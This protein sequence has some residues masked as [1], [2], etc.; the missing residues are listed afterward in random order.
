MSSETWFIKDRLP[1]SVL[2]AVDFVF[3][4]SARPSATRR[5]RNSE[6][7]ICGPFRTR[8]RYLR[9]SATSQRL[10]CAR[11]SR[12]KRAL[13]AGLDVAVPNASVGASLDSNLQN[14]MNTSRGA[15]ISYLLLGFLLIFGCGMSAASAQDQKGASIQQ[16]MSPEEF[17]A[18]GLNKLSPEEL[19]KLD[20]WLQGYRAT[21]EKT[22]EKKVKQSFFKFGE[23]SLSRVDGSFGGLK[24]RTL[25]KLED[26]TVW[27]QANIDD[28]YGPSPIDHPGAEVVHT[29]FGYKMRIQGVPEFYVNPAPT[30]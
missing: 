7:V 16:L 27:K 12:A 25:I 30:H 20:A 21:T 14:I 9:P 5:I 23:A 24:G 13:S 11:V 4:W 28:H 15:L 10:E 17:S 19:Q 3:Q 6:K 1:A 26:G 18:A 2:F 8:P 29:G 22:T